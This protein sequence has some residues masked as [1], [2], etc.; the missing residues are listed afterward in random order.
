MITTEMKQK[1]FKK[2]LETRSKIFV[3]LLNISM[4]KKKQF[5]NKLFVMNLLYKFKV[6]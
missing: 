5:K 1:Q 6:A 2:P 3:T 4:F